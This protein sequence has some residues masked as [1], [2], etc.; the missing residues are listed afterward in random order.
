MEAT[1]MIEMKSYL[2]QLSEFQR[3][4]T[5][6]PIGSLPLQVLKCQRVGT[7]GKTESAIKKFFKPTGLGFPPNRA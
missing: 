3:I 4:L 1:G 2:S 5:Q 7:D 6:A